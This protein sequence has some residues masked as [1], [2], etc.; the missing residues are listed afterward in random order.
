[1]K[2]KRQFRPVAILG[3]KRLPFCKMSTEY[4]ERS[5]IDLMLA[6]L[7][8]TVARFDLA[9]KSRGQCLGEVVLGTTFFHPQSW[10]LAR[11]VV[12]RSSLSADT[13]GIGLQRAC[14]TSLDAA[15]VVAERIALSAIDAGLAGGVESLSNTTFYLSD[16]LARRLVQSN[17]TRGFIEKLA[18][19]SGLSIKDL[20]P[21]TPPAFEATT[22]KS[23]GE[24]CEEM[25]KHWK[26]TRAEQDELALKSHQN[27]VA[28]YNRGFYSD[29]VEPHLGV[30]QDN[31]L[32]AD[33]SLEKLSKLKPAFDRSE[34][35]TL[36][37]GNSSPL[38][39]GAATV[40]LSSE[41]W[42]QKMNHEVLAYLVDFEVAAIDPR[43][44]GLLMAP[45]Y[46][47]PRMLQRLNLKL[48]DFD[49]YEIH[50]A[51]AAQVLCTLRA[52]QSDDFCRQQGLSQALGSID[53]SKL[54]TVGGSVALGH[55]FG[56]TGARIL[57]TAAQLLAEKGSGRALISIC[58]GGGMG[59][60]AVIEK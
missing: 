15:L 45:A 9:Q 42:A 34:S 22:G 12:L 1:M 55:P 17:R 44:E 20:W 14:A 56:A 47:V 5:P 26:I 30:K 13:P 57:A 50:E 29:L 2:F 53:R 28:A 39:D 21:K 33:T 24:H 54:N 27:G 36:T 41:E 10:N 8:A 60:V 51:F 49:F 43:S 31:N 58:T 18:L 46:A 40:L 32:R 52:W 6:S 19:F 48:Q 4:A 3:G 38:T 16:P 59:T 11:E 37:A 7:E 23:M 35:G 25:A